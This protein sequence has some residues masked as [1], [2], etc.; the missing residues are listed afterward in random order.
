[1]SLDE[2]VLE[3]VRENAEKYPHAVYDSVS[4]HGACLYDEGRV[5]E[6]PE[7]EGCILREVVEYLAP[8]KLDSREGIAAVLEDARVSLHP[9]TL[10]VLESMQFAQDVGVRWGVA[11]RRARKIVNGVD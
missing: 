1:M 3:L 2:K 8:E 10:R 6:G 4:I 11:W 7:R 5:L 9:D